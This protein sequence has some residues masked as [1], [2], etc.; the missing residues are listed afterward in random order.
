MLIEVMVKESIAEILEVPQDYVTPSEDLVLVRIY[1]T[2]DITNPT[3]IMIGCDEYE[4]Y[5]LVVED[6]D[7]S[8]DYLPAE[9]KTLQELFDELLKEITQQND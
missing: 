6:N 9:G 3:Y 4:K 7:T 5:Y 2:Y 8:E 1:H